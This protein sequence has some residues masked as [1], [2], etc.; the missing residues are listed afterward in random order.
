MGD[1]QDD[2]ERRALDELY[3]LAYEDL[4]HRAARVRRG[5]S[6]SI[7]P[8]T[9]VH[10]AWEKLAKTPAVARTDRDH[11]LG[12]AAHAMRQVL[13]DT[14]RRRRASKR[15]GGAPLV[16]WDDDAIAATASATADYLLGIE[17]E[18]E[19]LAPTQP[20][21]VKVFECRFFGGLDVAETAAALQVSRE[22][23]QR[24]WKKVRTWLE[25]ALREFRS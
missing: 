3:S 17:R 13:I 4:R 25:N 2:S 18:L 8:T 24:D 6:L 19:N 22:T 11:F 21:W 12:I 10:A 7:S 14:A 5:S 15:G 9:L 23:V 20:R 1:L 16:T